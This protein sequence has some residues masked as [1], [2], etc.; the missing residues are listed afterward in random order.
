MCVDK[1]LNKNS[2]EPNTPCYKIYKI[3]VVETKS[4]IEINQKI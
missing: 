2:K 4:K 1:A 3:N